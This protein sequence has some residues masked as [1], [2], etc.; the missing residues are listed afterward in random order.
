MRRTSVRAQ[1]RVFASVAGRE[2]CVGL[3]G[4][5]VEVEHVGEDFRGDSP[6]KP[7]SGGSLQLG[8]AGFQR[9]EVSAE[10]LR[11]AGATRHPAGE[12]PAASV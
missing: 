7:K 2:V 6:G 10:V 3:E 11:V 5:D 12:E 1:G 4:A 9:A 8:D